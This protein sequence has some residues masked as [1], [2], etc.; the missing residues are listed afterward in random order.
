MAAPLVVKVCGLTRRE[1]A[2]WARECGADWLGFIVHGESPRRVEPEAMAGILESLPGA[3]GVAVMVGVGP[4]EALALGHRCHASRV[5]LHRVDPASWPE[6][7]PLPCTFGVGVTLEGALVGHEPSAAHLLLLDTAHGPLAGGSG[8]P[9]DW[10]IAA[11]IA[12]RRP[13]LLAGGLHGDNVAEAIAR[14]HPAGVDASSAL[15][16]APGLKD[17]ERVRRFVAAA[18]AASRT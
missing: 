4:D 10:S 15:E 17:P 1:D 2:A 5:Q 6:D 9:F 11:P 14:V 8:R 16:S 18:R 3:V 7:F 13:V 12:A